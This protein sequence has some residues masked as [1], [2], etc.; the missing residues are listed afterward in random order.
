MEALAPLVSRYA[1]KHCPSPAADCE[2][3]YVF[4]TPQGRQVAH[5]A[6]DLRALTKDYPTALGIVSM[7][8]TQMRKL[9]ATEVARDGSDQ[10]VRTV[11]THMTHGPETAKKYYQHLEEVQQSVSAFEEISSRTRAAPL[12][13]Q[14]ITPRLKKRKMWLTEELLKTHMDM[15]KTPNLEDCQAFLKQYRD[16]KLFICR[17]GK[18]LQDKCRTIKRQQERQRDTG[19]HNTLV[20]IV[21]M[22]CTLMM[23]MYSCI[24]RF[25]TST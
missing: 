7:T 15:E 11:A 25:F 13:P 9:T 6:D 20:V 2:A 19:T 16:D 1:E 5:I 14:E 17:T 8:T 24:H 12:E 4:L 22:H 23:H 18:E 3:G 10:V 21:V